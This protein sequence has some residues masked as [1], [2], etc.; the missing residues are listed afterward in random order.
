MRAVRGPGR[1]GRGRSGRA[2]PGQAAPARTATRPG[3][4]LLACCLVACSVEGSPD[5]LSLRRAAAPAGPLPARDGV[6]PVS[7]R[8][9]HV[10]QN[11]LLRTTPGKRRHSGS[12]TT[13]SSPSH[14]L[15][16]ATALSTAFSA[17]RARVR[18]E[19]ASSAVCEESAPREMAAPTAVAREADGGTASRCPETPNIISAPPLD[20]QAGA[21]QRKG[22]ES[23]C[24]PTVPTLG[25]RQPSGQITSPARYSPGN[26][27]Q[28]GVPRAA[29]DAPL[30]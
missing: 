30:R 11:A 23:P 10:F 8:R 15:P 7:R 24:R 18:T 21:G 4:L 9:V 6:S 19:G 22:A 27:T 16:R 13:Q 25:T 12:P 28:V 26:G 29:G 14:S 1:S 20:P 5:D 17:A 3:P 2:G